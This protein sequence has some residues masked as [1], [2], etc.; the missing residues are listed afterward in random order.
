MAEFPINLSAEL[1]GFLDAQNHPLRMEIEQL[2][3]LILS[4]E[5]GLTE[6]IKWNGPSYSFAGEDR[7][8]MRIN[9][10]KQLQLIFHRGAKVKPQ[11]KEKLIQDDFKLLVWKENDRA[12]ATLK[13]REELENN[14]DNLKAIIK[15]WIIAAS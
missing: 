14:A 3:F 1:T 10:P 4:A 5:T 15:A 6:S 7:I 12:V 13:N 8:S 9:P 2:R 11:P